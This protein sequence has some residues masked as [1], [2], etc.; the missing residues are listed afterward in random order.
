MESASFC[1]GY[2][3]NRLYGSAVYIPGECE[4]WLVY[5]S[6]ECVGSLLFVGSGGVD[7]GEL[8]NM[9]GSFLPLIELVRFCADFTLESFPSSI[10]LV[11]VEWLVFFRGLSQFPCHSLE[12]S[13]HCFLAGFL[14]MASM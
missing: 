10:L 3:Y 7:G 11:S 13:N 6:G 5:L 14:F 1:V 4:D 9:L 2:E 12:G 8:G